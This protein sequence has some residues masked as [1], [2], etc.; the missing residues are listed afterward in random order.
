MKAP[1]QPRPGAFSIEYRKTVRTPTSTSTDRFSWAS[2]GHRDLPGQGINHKR[3]HQKEQYPASDRTA[4]GN[5]ATRQKR[6]D[7]ALHQTIH[8]NGSFART[9][10]LVM[11]RSSRM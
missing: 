3:K 7:R 4:K 2:G 6:V 9:T 1:G 8:L 10:A 11:E 5:S